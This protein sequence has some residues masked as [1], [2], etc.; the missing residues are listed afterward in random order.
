MYS[1][2]KFK[3]IGMVNFNWGPVSLNY[4]ILNIFWT[5]HLYLKL[6]CTYSCIGTSEIN[7]AKAANKIFLAKTTTEGVWLVPCVL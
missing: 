7:T 4:I 1:L 5:F 2:N 6:I 3:L